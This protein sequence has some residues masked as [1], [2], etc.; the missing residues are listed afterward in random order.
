[1]ASSFKGIYRAYDF[2]YGVNPDAGGALQVISGSIS[3]GAY[4]I[5]CS[6]V[7]GESAD[8]KPCVISTSTPITIGGDSGI[9]TVTPS[10]VS[11]NQLNQ[12]LIT[13]TF[14][15]AHGTGAQVRS[16]SFG[17]AEAGAYASTK[18]GG[19][20]AIDAGWAAAGGTQALVTAYSF[21]A[22]VQLLDLRANGT[23]SSFTY[24]LTNAQILG[25]EAAPVELLP[26]PDANSFY[27]ITEAVLVNLNTGVAYTGG[28][29][30][31]VG[32]GTSFSPDALSGTVA[33]TFLT[34]PTA[35]AIAALAGSQISA[36][37]STNSSSYLAKGI[38]ISNASAPFAAGTGTLQITLSFIKI[39]T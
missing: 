5:T 23:P 16:G 9:E 37:T 32:Y 17:L 12:V 21:P 4:T 27:V 31:T 28:G 18:G 38:Y 26:A 22:G 24:T 10:A 13:A 20:V 15:Y 25:M 11:V 34:D 1:M 6:P 2:A 39:L 30:I 14:T 36:P 35:T 3:T 33:A 19:V 8:G 29:A 7:Q